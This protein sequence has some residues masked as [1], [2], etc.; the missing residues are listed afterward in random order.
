MEEFLNN[1]L[2]ELGFDASWLKSGLLEKSWLLEAAKNWQAEP[3]PTEH[4]RYAAFRE[5]LRTHQGFTQA[6][7]EEFLRLIEDDSDTFM[8]GA[9]WVDLLRWRYL[10]QEQFLQLSQ[11]PWAERFGKILERERAARGKFSL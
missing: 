5:I 10:T 11:H 4:F 9:A 6:Q 2:S 8:A 1:A 7:L 3:G